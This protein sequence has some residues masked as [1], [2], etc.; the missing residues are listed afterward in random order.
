M[1]IVGTQENICLMLNEGKALS[2]FVEREMEY[3]GLFKVILGQWGSKPG[4][5][6]PK[7]S[8]TYAT[9][10]KQ[11]FAEGHPPPSSVESQRP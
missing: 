10:N 3:R 8:T 5:L 11:L 7:A 2:P 9:Q 4:L 6:M 1:H